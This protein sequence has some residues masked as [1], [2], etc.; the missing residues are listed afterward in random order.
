MAT[1]TTETVT[2]DTVETTD[3]VSTDT[4]TD[5]T[6]EPTETVEPTDQ[7]AST[8]QEQQLP[9]T[10][11]LVKTLAAQKEELRTLRQE[12]QKVKEL[13][14]QV[15]ELTTRAETADQIKAKYNRLEE[16]IT[17]AGGPLGRALDSMS[18]TKALFE[19]DTS[20]EDIVRDWHKDN[21]SATSVALGGT[22]APSGV[23]P[24][25]NALLRTAANK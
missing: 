18:F 19:S 6:S 4:T 23:K 7:E 17:K 3:H 24:D 22:V 21:P 14:A 16:F 11:P 8:Q 12:G 9:D 20:V 10:H 15:A 5:A 13:E 2:E 1:E 25:M